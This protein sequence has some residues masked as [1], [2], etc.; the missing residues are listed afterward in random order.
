MH[1]HIIH[2]IWQ[3]V[4]LSPF[5]KYFPLNLVCFAV[6]LISMSKKVFAFADGAKINKLAE[7]KIE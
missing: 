5:M 4:D 6:C 2:V 1:I 3:H 7:D